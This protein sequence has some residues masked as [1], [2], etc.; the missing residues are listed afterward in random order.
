MIAFE[1]DELQVGRHPVDQALDDL[2]ALRAAIDVVTERHDGGRPAHLRVLNDLHHR[3]HKEVV[4]SVQVGDHIGKRHHFTSITSTSAAR[5]RQDCRSGSTSSRSNPMGRRSLEAQST[6]NFE[7]NRDGEASDADA[8]RQSP[9]NG[10]LHEVGREERECEIFLGGGNLTNS[11]PG[12]N[13][14]GCSLG[15]PEY[16][17]NTTKALGA[18]GGVAIGAAG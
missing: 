18:G 9:L 11:S 12:R 4:A 1:A 5:S 10:G 3:L 15:T 8:A 14:S 17:L 13:R 2:A 6:G 16:G 7:A